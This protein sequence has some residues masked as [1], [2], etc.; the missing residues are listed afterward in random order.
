MLDRGVVMV[1]PS[2]VACRRMKEE[3]GEPLSDARGGQGK[4]KPPPNN[5]PRQYSSCLMYVHMTDI[6]MSL[7]HGT[8]AGRRSQKCLTSRAWRRT[9]FN[10]LPGTPTVA[11]PQ[12]VI[13][14]PFFIVS[15]VPTTSKNKR[16]WRCSKHDK[17]V[18]Y[19]LPDLNCY[20]KVIFSRPPYSHSSP[21][22]SVAKKRLLSPSS[23]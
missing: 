20:A 4:M 21:F 2:P 11:Q 10:A 12:T 13:P 16:N 7:W 9:S 5:V 8:H 17:S 18:F 6:K 19:I 14:L 3:C 1:L 23:K 22:H 15:S